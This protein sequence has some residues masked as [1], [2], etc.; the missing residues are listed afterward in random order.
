M[1]SDASLMHFHLSFFIFSEAKV[2]N[3]NL[4]LT[5]HLPQPCL[6]ATFLGGWDA[7]QAGGCTRKASRMV[8]WSGLELCGQGD[9]FRQDLYF[10]LGFGFLWYVWNAY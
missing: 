9:I 5:Q 3:L 1:V 10:S 4:T 6:P 8:F 7:E 2:L